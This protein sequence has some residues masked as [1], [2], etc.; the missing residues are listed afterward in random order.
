MPGLEAAVQLGQRRVA[1]GIDDGFGE[2]RR[3]WMALVDAET[4]WF[5]LMM[6]LMA[7]EGSAVSIMHVDVESGP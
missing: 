4:V 2:G 7:D 3:L 6:L 5:I 1:D